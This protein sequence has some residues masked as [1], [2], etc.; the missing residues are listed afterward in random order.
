MRWLV[1][2]AVATAVAIIMLYISWEFMG[3]P[4]IGEVLSDQ[5]SLA[6][7]A[8]SIFI[9][10]ASLSYLLSHY[11]DEKYRR[12]Y[13][14]IKRLRNMVDAYQVVLNSMNRDLEQLKKDLEGRYIPAISNSI[15]NLEKRV[16]ASEKLI[17]V[18]IELLASEK[19]GK[20]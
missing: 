13:E 6:A 4:A 16:A 10:T 7:L 5:R 20:G 12:A 19:G 3:L 11:A 8:A 17:S 18:L 1:A 14:E 2:S 9:P 15:S